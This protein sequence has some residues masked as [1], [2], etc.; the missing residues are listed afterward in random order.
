MSRN[1]HLLI[2]FFQVKKLQFVP[3]NSFMLSRKLLLAGRA[4]LG[5]KLN[6]LGCFLIEEIILPVIIDPDGNPTT[7]RGKRFISRKVF[8][9]VCWNLKISILSKMM[10]S[11]FFTGPKSASSKARENIFWLPSWCT[12]ASKTRF[13]WKFY[14]TLCQPPGLL[15]L[16]RL[17]NFPSAEMG[18]GQKIAYSSKEQAKYFR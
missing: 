16:S 14:G 12:I 1:Q 8:F 9:L 4:F 3:I 17:I 15:G 10:I 13:K 5:Q 11:W 18:T 7:N 6:G 2:F